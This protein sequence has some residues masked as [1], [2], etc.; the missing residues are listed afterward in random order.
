MTIVESWNN[1]AWVQQW[2]KG[3]GR[4]WNDLEEM[5]LSDVKASGHKFGATNLVVK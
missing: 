5:S 2:L 4:C 1:S 3:V